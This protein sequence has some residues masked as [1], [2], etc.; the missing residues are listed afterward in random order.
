MA[1]NMRR[2][3]NAASGGAEV[4]NY[5]LSL[6]MRGEDFTQLRSGDW[7]ES[8]LGRSYFRS[9][10]T[11]LPDNFDRSSI[12]TWCY[13]ARWTTFIWS[14]SAKKVHLDRDCAAA[15]RIADETR[16]EIAISW[17]AATG[18]S[19]TLAGFLTKI[20]NRELCESCR[21]RGPHQGSM[22]TF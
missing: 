15:K 10:I 21:L 14:A 7:T 12:L 20:G 22:N 18:A 13:R 3:T 8:V 2:R 17:H 1:R 11:R 19:R 9:I 16:I 5:W 4:D 6:T